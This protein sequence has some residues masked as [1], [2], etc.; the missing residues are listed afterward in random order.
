MASALIVSTTEYAAKFSD[1]LARAGY[2]SV[3]QAYS[4]IGR[5]SCR[6]RGLAGV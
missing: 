6:A 3:R 5:A 4:E 1:V 2:D